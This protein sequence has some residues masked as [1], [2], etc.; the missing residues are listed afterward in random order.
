LFVDDPLA[1]AALRGL[2]LHPSC[3]AGPSE[4]NIIAVFREC[5]VEPG[6]R[7]RTPACRGSKLPMPPM[8]G[9]PNV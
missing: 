4:P 5:R 3:L 2:R 7:A 9:K 8:T 6:A 1:G